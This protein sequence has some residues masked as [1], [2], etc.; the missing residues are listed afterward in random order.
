MIGRIMGVGGQTLRRMCLVY[1]CHVSICGAG[2]RKDPKEEE[3]LLRTGDPR[4]NHLS[5]PLHAEISTVGPPHIA[6]TRLGQILSLLNRIII[7]V[8]GRSLSV[9]REFDAY[10]A[11][12]RRF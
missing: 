11:A 10:A 5:C 2:S 8:S 6:Y 1:K 9:S 4:H 12:G 3:E 7:S